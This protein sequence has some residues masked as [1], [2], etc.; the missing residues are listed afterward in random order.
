[1][2]LAEAVLAT[3]TPRSSSPCLLDSQ[4]SERWSLQPAL[5][6]SKTELLTS[7]LPMGSPVSVMPPSRTP[8][9]WTKKLRIIL[10]LSLHPLSPAFNDW[11]SR[12]SSKVSWMCP[13]PTT[14]TATPRV[15]LPAGF[16]ST[17][18]PLELILHRAD[19]A[20]KNWSQIKSFPWLQPSKGFS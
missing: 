19:R 13:L 17:L 14:F 2:T 10:N 5:S 16:P 12:V 18:T 20:L 15:S 8:A 4:G 3:P 11:G 9:A 6:V 1:M 7:L